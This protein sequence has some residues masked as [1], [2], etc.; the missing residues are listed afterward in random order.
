MP[1]PTP[2]PVRE[3]KVGDPVVFIGRDGKP[4]KATA[5]YID[6]KDSTLI[7]IKGDNNLSVV[8]VPHDPDGRKPESWNFSPAK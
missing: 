7:G 6:R 4:L 1:D 8:G 3:L 2:K 5:Y